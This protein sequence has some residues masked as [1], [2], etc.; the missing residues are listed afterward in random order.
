MLIVFAVIAVVAVIVA[1]WA[2]ATRNDGPPGNEAQS[3]EETMEP[4]EKL[5]D[6]IAL[7]QFAWLYLKADTI[8]QTLTFDNPPQNYVQ[9]RVSI[10]LDDETLWESEL[11]KPGE[12]SGPVV[13]TRPLKTGE[14][15]ANLVYTCFTN[16]EEMNSLNGANSPI[17]LKVQ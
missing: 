16:D 17:T 3:P 5:T 14:Y 11:L 10:V 4:I 9:L 8:E 6:T 1:V 15:G 2:I 7:P 12:S 13:L